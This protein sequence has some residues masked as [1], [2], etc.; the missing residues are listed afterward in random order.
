VFLIPAPKDPLKRAEWIKKL[1][2]NWRGKPKSEEQRRRMS[3]AE[4][5][6]WWILNIVGN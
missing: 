6:E 1:S 4:K 3:E 2:D 5:R